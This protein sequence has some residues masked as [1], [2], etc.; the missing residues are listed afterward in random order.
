VHLFRGLGGYWNLCL[1]SRLLQ[2]SGFWRG[3]FNWY[4]FRDH[5]PFD[6]CFCHRKT[7]DVNTQGL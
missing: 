7:C 4:G 6:L 2:H 1:S 3:A 5:G